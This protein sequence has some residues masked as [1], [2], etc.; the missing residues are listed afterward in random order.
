MKD[1]FL[2]AV[3][4]VAAF[5]LGG[6]MVGMGFADFLEPEPPPPLEAPKLEPPPPIEQSGPDV[7]QI[8]AENIETLRKLLQDHT[9]KT[10]TFMADGRKVDDPARP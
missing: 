5:F 3:F 10:I 4:C 9:G 6:V 8:N 2:P 7:P 1:G